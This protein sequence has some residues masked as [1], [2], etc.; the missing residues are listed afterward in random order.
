LLI[1]EENLQRYNVA[2][3]GGGPA[4]AAV[5]LSLQKH[6]PS[7]A[8]AIIESSDYGQ[9]RIGETL[10]P[11]VQPLLAQL[12]VWES[13]LAEDHLPAYGTWSAWGTD[14]LESNEFIYG[15]FGRGWHLDRRRFDA[16]LA[17]EAATRGVELLTNSCPANFSLPEACA[18]DAP[19]QTEVCRTFSE[20]S[21]KRRWRLT[22]RNNDNERFPI[23][24]DFVVDA[25]GKRASFA[26]RQGARKI[27]FDQLLGAFV[28]LK[29]DATTAD[30]CTLV[31]AAEDG[32]WYS[33]LLPGSGIVAA[34]MSDA[35]IV[36]KHRL[37]DAS[38]WFEQM[39]RTVHTKHRLLP[40]EPLNKPELHAAYSHRLDRM[41]GDRWLAVGDAAMAFDPLSSQGIFKALRSGILASYA[42]CDFFKGDL[43]GLE[44][45][46]S[47]AAREFDG[48]LKTRAEFYGQEQRWP[49]SPFWQRR[50][51]QVVFQEER[52]HGDQNL[53]HR[54]S[55][56]SQL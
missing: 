25:T 2:I 54:H 6:T 10:P 8:V 30:S 44:K 53:Q 38:R 29:C 9:Q 5:A 51:E 42:I 7:L 16:M 4:G 46:Q 37:K 21:H 3:L 1:G 24:A 47:I 50:H 27:L 20:Q 13:F 17:R 36:G 33:A 41:A 40:A 22:I 55:D 45:Y 48:Y 39:Q 14:E 56:L 18:K 11:T 19:R 52:K 49:D 23:E 32:W 12:G 35:D 15:K 34:W 31:E 26:T 43:S 28:F